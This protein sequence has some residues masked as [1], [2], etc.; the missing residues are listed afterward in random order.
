MAEV[1]DIVSVILDEMDRE[2]TTYQT[3]YHKYHQGD[4]EIAKLIHKRLV[5]LCKRLLKEI[6]KGKE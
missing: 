1:S 2:Y 4:D 3:L 5:D 6:S